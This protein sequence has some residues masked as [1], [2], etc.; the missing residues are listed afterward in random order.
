MPE[1]SFSFPN[2]KSDATQNPAS[3][4]TLSEGPLPR[5]AGQRHSGTPGLGALLFPCP[6]ESQR[7]TANTE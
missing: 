4:E 7:G 5:T 2:H 6:Q 3:L 1:F